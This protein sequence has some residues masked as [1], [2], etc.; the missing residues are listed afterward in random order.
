MTEYVLL[1]IIVFLVIRVINAHRKNCTEKELTDNI[2][3][4]CER[5]NG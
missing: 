2:N 5:N 1:L 3:G 4:F